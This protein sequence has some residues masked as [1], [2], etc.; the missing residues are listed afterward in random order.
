[1]L[2]NTLPH[3]EISDL[4]PHTHV[5]GIKVDEGADESSKAEQGKVET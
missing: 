3:Q 2:L 5:P 4:Y 1:M